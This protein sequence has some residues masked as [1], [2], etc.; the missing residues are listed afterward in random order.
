VVEEATSSVAVLGLPGFVL[1]AV[2]EI[3]T[4]L[5][6]TIETTT[7]LVG[8][9]SC[10]VVAKPKDRREVVLRDLP[11]SGRA[12]RLRWRKRVWAC[13]DPDCGTRTW[14]EESWLA[15]PRRHLTNR[16]RAEICR[17][18]GED[19]DA[20]AACAKDYGV[21]W[22]TAMECVL[23]VGTPMVDDPSRIEGASAVGLDE[24][25]YLH[26]RRGRR[27]V[28]VTGVVD[29]ETGALLDVFEGRDAADLRRWMAEMPTEWL[30]HIQVVSVDPHE[31]YRSAVHG[32]D[33]ITGRPSPWAHTT[34]VVDPFHI[35][36][37]ANQ[38]VTKCRQRTQ[39]TVL[40]HRGWKDDP[41]YSIRRLLL[42]G[43]ERLDE[44]GWERLT[45]GLDDGDRLDQVLDAWLA[46]EQVRDIYLTDDVE[47][48]AHRL[49]E[50]IAFCKASD[51]PELKTLAK[52]LVRWRSAILAHH[53]TGA[54]NGPVEAVNLT[55]KAV[56]RCGRGFRNFRNYRLRLLLVAGV[57]WQTPEVTRLRARPR[58]I[59]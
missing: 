32:D 55:I 35:V 38:A 34:L 58:F 11:A 15:A 52:S 44:R 9:K 16:A 37:L 6:Y 3:D 47:L 46:K 59:A 25:M 1:L 26:A 20:V 51:V 7:T 40:G 43:A 10:G 53:T 17:R 33:P 36:R 31:G 56:K 45:R 18:V 39:Q 49:D 41:L 12:I 42:V 29:V 2:T 30:A 54:S 57:Q 48:A 13:V 23:D 22:H 50:A 4:E 19:N 8:C 21:R 24:T 14:T 5:E 27:R 28:L